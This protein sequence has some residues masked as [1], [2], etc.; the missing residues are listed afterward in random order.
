MEGLTLE[1]EGEAAFDGR[2]VRVPGCFPE[3]VASV[4]IEH[5][6]RTTPLA[7]GRLLAL[8]TPHPARRTP[9]CIEHERR[10]GRCS[11]C[12]L[13]PLDEEAQRALKRELLAQRFGLQ[14]DRV[15]HAG[16]GLGYR[17][18][19]KRVAFE[20]GPSRL[21]L[22]S[23]AR[24]THTPAS[25]R[26]CA[27]DHPRIVAAFDELERAANTLGIAAYD[28][29]TGEGELRYAWAK[30]DGS[31]V[32]LTLVLAHATGRAASE[33]PALLKS[34]AAVALSIQ[35]KATNAMRGQ[36]AQMVRGQSSLSMTLLGA[37][38]E[39]TALG[40]MQPNPEVA[41]LCYAALLGLDASAP[42]HGRLAFD[43]YAGAGL[44][45]RL[46][47]T[48][49]DEVLAC[50]A[51]PESAQA[52]GIAAETAEAFLA[53]QLERTQPQPPELV[54]ANPPRKGLGERVCALLCELGAT[55]V[56]IM[57][58]GPEG[59]SRDLSLLSAR[60]TLESLTAFDTLSQTPHVELVAKLRLR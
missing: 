7:H 47:R 49:F 21:F 13:M 34:V 3:E 25:M 55:K 37:E 41:A 16:P 36:T 59:L 1:G 38:L 10:A 6:A 22:G 32:L 53:A 42:E 8:E 33:L 40:F 11:G 26:G 27:V 45:T 57:S 12:A 5:V 30:T 17:H 52:L 48:R 44:T 39:V 43:L 19:S 20:G 28:E 23:F 35:D 46:L 50:E 54:V 58:C 60:Y 18:S 2:T 4:R 15:V 56:H 31:E 29:R 24:G 9:P 51:H 14:V